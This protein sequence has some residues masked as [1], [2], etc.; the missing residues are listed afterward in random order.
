MSGRATVHIDLSGS[1]NKVKI[2]LIQDKNKNGKLDRGEILA[3]Q[4]GSSTTRAI[5]K[6]LSPATYFVRVSTPGAVSYSLQF[7]TFPMS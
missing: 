3:Q 1:G 6:I 4:G 2:A 5:T 7:V